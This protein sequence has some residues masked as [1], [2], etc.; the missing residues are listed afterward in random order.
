MQGINDEGDMP[1][2]ME[3][4]KWFQ[5]LGIKRGLSNARP[6]D[7]NLSDLYEF[8][9]VLKI[10]KGV[11]REMQEDTCSASQCHEVIEKLNAKNIKIVADD[12]YS[13]SDVTCAILMG[14]KYG[15]GY[16]LSRNHSMPKPVRKQKKNQVNPYYDRKIDFFHDLAWV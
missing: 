7:F 3:L 13:K 1:H 11:I 14:I 16:F 4:L 6:L 9:D 12:L 8:V 15:Q 10:K 5:N 2:Q